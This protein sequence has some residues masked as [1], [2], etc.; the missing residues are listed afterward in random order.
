MTTF[1]LDF[2]TLGVDAIATAIGKVVKIGLGY[3]LEGQAANMALPIT[4]YVIHP[5]M[6]DK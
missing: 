2:A 4:I 6:L 1:T 5:K 3:S